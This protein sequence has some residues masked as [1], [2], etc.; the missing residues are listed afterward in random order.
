MRID[1]NIPFENAKMIRTHKHHEM[2]DKMSFGDSVFFERR[3]DGI[4]FSQ[5]FVEWIKK[6][7]KFPLLFDV[8]LTNYKGD[9]YKATRKVQY[10][11]GRSIN[12]GYRVWLLDG[13]K[14]YEN[15]FQISPLKTIQRY[16]GQ[17]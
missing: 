1:K 12:S 16:L 6:T 8:I 3:V 11:Y 4:N 10:V 9:K 2:F 13:R 15:E 17:H 14:K 7:K 5:R